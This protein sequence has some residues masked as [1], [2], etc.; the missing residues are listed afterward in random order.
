MQ[1]IYS[2]RSDD[3]ICYI[4]Y[5]PSYLY[6]LI[7]MFFRYILKILLNEILNKVKNNNRKIYC[8]QI[9]T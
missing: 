4:I 2:N 7:V 1:I 9:F 5:L 3:W 6:G 8:I